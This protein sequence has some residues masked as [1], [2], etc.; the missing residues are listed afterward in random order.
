MKVKC[1]AHFKEAID[2]DKERKERSITLTKYIVTRVN[3]CNGVQ[4]FVGDLGTLMQ[5]HLNKI[6]L[7]HIMTWISISIVWQWNLA[8]G[9]KHSTSERTIACFP[10]CYAKWLWT[11]GAHHSRI[12]K[13]FHGLPQGR[14]KDV[15]DPVGSLT[16]NQNVY[17]IFLR[18]GSGGG[19]LN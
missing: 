4:A 14:I 17:T 18:S 3:A 2:Q 19:V 12:L 9:S 1:H 16:L 11:R 15:G 13:C 7:T 5:K 10:Q 8:G 6:I